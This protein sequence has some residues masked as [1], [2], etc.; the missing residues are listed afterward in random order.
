MLFVLLLTLSLASRHVPLSA[1][2]GVAQ[3]QVLCK[4]VAV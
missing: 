1:L 3:A 2:A 4:E